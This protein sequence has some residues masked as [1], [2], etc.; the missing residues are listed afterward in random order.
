[1]LGFTQM[2]LNF[3]MFWGIAIMLYEATLTARSIGVS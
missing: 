3:S 1:V 2:E